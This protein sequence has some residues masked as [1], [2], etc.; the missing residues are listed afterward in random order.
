VVRT[1]RSALL[2]SMGGASGV[3]FGTFFRGAAKRLD[4][5]TAFDSEA[6]RRLLSALP[7]SRTACK[8]SIIGGRRESA[9]FQFAPGGFEAT[10]H[11]DSVVSVSH[12]PVGP[13][14]LVRLLLDRPRDVQEHRP[15]V[16]QRQRALRHR[17][18]PS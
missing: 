10:G 12:C 3:V 2:T 7:R 9:V 8:P 11:S 4:D 15:R 13:A 14:Q 16:L 5:W 18:R 1:A 6:P 17:F